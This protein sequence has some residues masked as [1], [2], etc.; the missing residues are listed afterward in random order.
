MWALG[1][2]HRLASAVF[3]G[4]GSGCQCVTSY[5]IHAQTVSVNLTLRT[6]AC[7]VRRCACRHDPSVLNTYIERLRIFPLELGTDSVSQGSARTRSAGMLHNAPDATLARL[8]SICRVVRLSV[9]VV[10]KNDSSPRPL[11]LH[12]STSPLPTI[13]LT[14]L[15]FTDF[16]SL[17]LQL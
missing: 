6:R 2:G 8:R 12:F 13:T 14:R 17:L 9:V 10:L 4:S 11:T 16:Q 3:G 1:S 7:N 5:G 15:A